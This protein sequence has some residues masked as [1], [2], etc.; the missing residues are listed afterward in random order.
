LRVSVASEIGAVG[1]GGERED[2]PADRH[3]RLTAVAGLGPGLAVGL[4]LLALL[5]VQR[6]AA[7]VVLQR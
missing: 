2:A 1:V 6:F 4:D 5:D 3:P 7:F